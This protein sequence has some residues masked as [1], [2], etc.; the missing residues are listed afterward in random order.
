MKKLTIAIALMAAAAVFAS[1]LTHHKSPL[2]AGKRTAPS[3]IQADFPAPICPP[4]CAIPTPN[5]IPN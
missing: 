1:P 4:A 5:Q 2:N 3:T